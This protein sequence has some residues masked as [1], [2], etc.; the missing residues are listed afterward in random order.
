MGLT[1]SPLGSYSS[2]HTQTQVHGKC[3]LSTNTYQRGSEE[4]GGDNSLLRESHYKAQV[5]LEH[6]NPPA[7]E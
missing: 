7:A 1:C 2:S 5:G 6:G 3:G 4:L